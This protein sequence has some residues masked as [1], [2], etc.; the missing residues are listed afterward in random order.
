LPLLSERERTILWAVIQRHIE[1]AEP[2]SSQDLCH[3]YGF[4]WSAP[5]VRNVMARLEETGLLCHPYTSAGKVP[6]VEAYRYF[7]ENLMNGPELT[8]DGGQVPGTRDALRDLRLE[9]LNQVRETDQILKLTT[10][11]LAMAT[12]LMAM[13]WIPSQAE[14]R[15]SAVRLSRLAPRKVLLELATS[16]GDEYHQV[17]DPGETVSAMLLN[18]VTAIINE[19]GRNARAEDLQALARADWQGLDYSMVLLLRQALLLAGSSLSIPS[20]DA[21]LLEGTANLIEQPEFNDISATRRLMTILDQRQELVRSLEGPGIE[22][23]G[24][25]VVIGEDDPAQPLPALSFVTDS[26]SLARGRLAWIGV[27]GPRRMAYNRVIPLVE[28]IGSA[29]IKASQTRKA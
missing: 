19:R 20:Q 28:R 9:I 22:K 5:T 24:I 18:R 2:V 10:K 29:V 8:E 11:V 16:S 12:H 6:T 14:A 1:T 25:H 15:L 7:V 21:F 26:L 23:R 13:A 3:H 4:G 27:V 17:F